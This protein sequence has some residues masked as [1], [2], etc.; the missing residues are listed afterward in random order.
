MQKNIANNYAKNSLQFLNV[1]K[2]NRHFCWL[3]VVQETRN[4]CELL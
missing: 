4:I 2:M 1:K 3:F